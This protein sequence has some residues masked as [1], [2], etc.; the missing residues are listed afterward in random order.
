MNRKALSLFLAIV[1][2]LLANSGY[3]D[4]KKDPKLSPEDSLLKTKINEFV[5][6]RLKTDIT[7]L[8]EKEKKM[9]PLLIEAG[10]I[11]D[12]LYWKQVIGDR[13]KFIDSISNPC[14]LYTSDAAD[15]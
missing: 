1:L 15:E 11:I 14:L 5:M 9:I 8:T 6:V 10:K 7:K 4:G 2:L 13:K 3:C 12:D